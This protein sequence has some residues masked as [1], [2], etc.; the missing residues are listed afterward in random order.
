LEVVEDLDPWKLPGVIGAEL[1]RETTAASAILQRIERSRSLSRH[2]LSALL[3]ASEAV[4]RIAMGSQQVSRLAEGRLRQS[5]ERLGLDRIV[6]QVIA[7]NDMHYFRAGIVVEPRLRPVE[8]IVDPGLLVSLCEAT[9]ACA[10]RYGQVLAVWLEISN[11]PQNGV[12]TIRARPHLPDSERPLTAVPDSLDWI[13]L[14]RLATAMGV[15]A[16]RVVTE[17][18]AIIT[19][20][21]P[22]TVQHLEGLTAIEVDGGGAWETNDSRPLAGHRVLLITADSKLRWE[23]EAVCRQMRLVL[24][25]V[26]T[27]QR[28]VACC[29]N[30]PPDLIVVDEEAHDEQFDQLRSDLLRYSNLPCV[31]I[32]SS[33]NVVEMSSW[34]GHSMSR[35]SRDAL[36]GQLQSILAVELAKVF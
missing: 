7:D 9:F 25:V 24:E 12:L 3:A 29:E 17:E 8:I 34:D 13:L 6:L 30:D 5:H 31:E 19:L 33:P 21:F 23:V 35:V 32:S 27:A 4:R 36:R 11:W 2:D 15:Q 18:Q 1:A 16:H 28:A 10:A 20:E 14:S 22:R 26:P